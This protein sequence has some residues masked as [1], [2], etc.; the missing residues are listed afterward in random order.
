[1]RQ[2]QSEAKRF[3]KPSLDRL[4]LALAEIQVRT[5]RAKIPAKSI[6]ASNQ[7]GTSFCLR[8]HLIKQNI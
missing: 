5:N 6:I 7:S 1:M 3:L 8:F 4:S 2:E